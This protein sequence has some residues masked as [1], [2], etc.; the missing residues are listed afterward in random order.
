MIENVDGVAGKIFESHEKFSS[1]NPPKF[2]QFHFS[3][4]LTIFNSSIN[5]LKITNY[6]IAKFLREKGEKKYE[7]NNFEKKISRLIKLLTIL[8]FKYRYFPFNRLKTKLPWKK[9]LVLI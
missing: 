4:I 2:F 6:K 1:S 5:F 3:Q 8:P 7:I 9:R